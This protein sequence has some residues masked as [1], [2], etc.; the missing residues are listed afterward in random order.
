[1]ATGRGETEKSKLSRRKS[2]ATTTPMMSSPRKPFGIMN[3][4]VCVV[5]GGM[6]FL[7]GNITGMHSGMNQGK[8]LC[9]R[10][11]ATLIADRD[12]L[13]RG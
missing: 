11:T 9:D 12:R 8:A 3:L 2:Q 5:V 7:L 1:M 10:D 6:S 13:N 4:L